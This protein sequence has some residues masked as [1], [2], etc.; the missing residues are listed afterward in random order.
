MKEVEGR[1]R[2]QSNSRDCGLEAE[3]GSMRPKIIIP[4]KQMRKTNITI[5]RKG[6]EKRP[7]SSRTAK[8]EGAR[9]LRSKREG[10]TKV[11]K[12]DKTKP[13]MREK[14]APATLARL[15]KSP[16]RK[17]ARIPGVRKEVIC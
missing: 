4:Q 17:V 3:F 13:P 14:R 8:P 6:I 16:P 10:T 15:K 11:S 7:S 5:S 12:R 9:G 2:E 1:K